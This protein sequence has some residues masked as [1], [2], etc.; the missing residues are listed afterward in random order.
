MN[1]LEDALASLPSLAD[2]NPETYHRT[3]LTEEYTRTL[4]FLGECA[5][6]HGEIATLREGVEMMGSDAMLTRLTHLEETIDHLVDVSSSEDNLPIPF[7]YTSPMDNFKNY[8]SCLE[9]VEY[10]LESLRRLDAFFCRG[11]E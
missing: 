11:D 10:R 1:A 2:G 9:R 4:K 8:L 7:S 3:L 6:V 5:A